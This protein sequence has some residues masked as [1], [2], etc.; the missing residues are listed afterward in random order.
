[1]RYIDLFFNWS[2]DMPGHVRCQ[3][4]RLANEI[5]SGWPFCSYLETLSYH[6][7]DDGC[8]RLFWGQC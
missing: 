5:K 3:G 2:H 1:M 4:I 6:L 8:K 7:Y